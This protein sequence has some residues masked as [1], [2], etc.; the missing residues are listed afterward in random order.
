MARFTRLLLSTVVA[1]ALAAN[2]AWAEDAPGSEQSIAEL[3]KQLDADEFTERQAASDKLAAKGEAAVPALREAA[4]G[5]SAEASTRS[6]EILR[7]HHE[8]S[9]AA[10]KKAADAA[11]A[12]IVKSEKGTVARR[13]KEIL[14]PATDPNVPPRTL[15][16]G[17]FPAPGG[18]RILPGRVAIEMRAI[19]GA[20]AK[21]ISV[22]STGDGAKE[23]EAVE[24]DRTVKINTAAGGEIKMKVTEKKDGKDETKEYEAK[25][26]D[27]LKTKH[28]EAH[29]LYEQYGL[30]AAGGV[31]IGAVPFGI[32]GGLLPVAPAA[33]MIARVRPMII[34]DPADLTERLNKA[35]KQLEEATA[36]IKKQAEGAANPA[37]LKKALEELEQ[38][39]KE[40]AGLKEKLGAPAADLIPLPVPVPSGE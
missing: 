10:V 1:T 20:G 13:A 3:I 37:E 15:V 21:R 28:P 30:Q 18:I 14:T 29:K 11:L 25:N 2:S 9:E 8:S 38:A 32:G 34:R 40:L 17:G 35:Q 24:G 23:I 31:R 6:L 5:T 39:S 7:K 4:E 22:K 36:R 26:A 16:P 12:E 19:G 33:P 27:E